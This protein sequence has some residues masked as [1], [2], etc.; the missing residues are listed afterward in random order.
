MNP[1]AGID[2]DFFFPWAGKCYRRKSIK[3][4]MT[5]P[6]PLLLYYDQFELTNEIGE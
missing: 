3:G 2:V 6:F 5:H 4:E 1:T